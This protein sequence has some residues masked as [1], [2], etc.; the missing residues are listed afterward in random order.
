M[1]VNG[2]NQTHFNPYQKQAQKH[3]AEK[4]KLKHQADQ[5]QISDQAKK[6]QE[7]ST[8]AANRKAYVEKIKHDVET[9]NYH[10]NH[11]KT[12]KKM[13]DFWTGK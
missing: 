6:M 11:E 13:I 2:S 3:T 8:A 9:G 4:Q 5:L 7:S 10:V 12:A 1:K